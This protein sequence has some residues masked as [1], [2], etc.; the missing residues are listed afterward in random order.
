MRKQDKNLKPFQKGFD[1]RRNLEGRPEGAKSLSTQLR[2]FLE[3]TVKDD[4]GE[5]TTFRDAIIKK[6]LQKAQKG[7][8][9]AIQEIFDRT[10]GKSK[11]SIEVEGD[12]KIQLTRRIVK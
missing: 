11:Q 7:D 5:N 6:L 1:E 3:T 9:K 8:I 12:M 2:E 10:E 4:D